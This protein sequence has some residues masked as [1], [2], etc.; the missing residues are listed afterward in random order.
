MAGLIRVRS[1]GGPRRRA[2]LSFGPEWQQLDGSEVNEAQFLAILEDAQLQLQKADDGENPEWTNFPDGWREAAIEALR[3]HVAY[4]IEHGEPHRMMVPAEEFQ[5]AQGAEGRSD[6]GAPDFVAPEAK[7]EEAKASAISS[8]DPE[9]TASAAAAEAEES[10][11]GA[12]DAAAGQGDAS[13]EENQLEESSR[14][15]V[16][17]EN[18]DAEDKPEGAPRRGPKNRA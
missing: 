12:D 11:E 2:G 5:S 3:E 17:A 1:P 18:T 4:D 9:G 14:P 7:D 8:A 6:E 13:D 16:A 10:R 15:P